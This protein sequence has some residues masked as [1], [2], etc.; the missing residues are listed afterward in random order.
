MQV[1]IRGDTMSRILSILHSGSAD[2]KHKKQEEEV[3]VGMKIL[4]ISISDI[5]T[6]RCNRQDSKTTKS[7]TVNSI[8]YFNPER[9]SLKR[10]LSNFQVKLYRWRNLLPILISSPGLV[11]FHK[12]Q[13][14][15]VKP[16]ERE[17][18]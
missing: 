2:I 1:E 8:A 16:R 18:E 13:S 6:V 7:Q 15:A 17:V 12:L 3:L 14:D 10:K 5:E 9:F 4:G 11:V